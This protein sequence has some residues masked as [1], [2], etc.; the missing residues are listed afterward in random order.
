MI[1]KHF[2]IKETE[3]KLCEKTKTREKNNDII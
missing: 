3:I 1:F 2:V